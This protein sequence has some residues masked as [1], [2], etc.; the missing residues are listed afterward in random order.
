MTADLD[1]L[2]TNIWYYA[3]NQQYPWAVEYY[4]DV[5]AGDRI[6]YVSRYIA[7]EFY[8][9]MAQTRGT[10]GKDRAYD[11]LQTLWNADAAFS[12]HP[13]VLSGYELREIRYNP[14]NLLLSDVLG[15]DYGDAPIIADA[16]AIAHLVSA[17]DP[18]TY[19]THN[20]P[21]YSEEYRLLRHVHDSGIDEITARIVTR[22]NDFVETDLTTFGIENVEIQTV[23]S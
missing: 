13:Y 17:F 18:A 11:H 21:N 1:V 14:R 8:R 4:E 3:V 2:D 22:E 9:K 19:A 6:V 12:V 10:E 5:I 23:P 16:H 20:T 15:V 7:A